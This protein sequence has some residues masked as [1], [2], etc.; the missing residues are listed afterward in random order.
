MQVT[1]VNSALKNEPSLI[2]KKPVD[3]IIGVM[4]FELSDNRVLIRPAIRVIR[5]GN[6]SQLWFSQVFAF[7]VKFV[8]KDG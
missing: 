5:L 4:F 6:A 2:N 3:G 1:A 8:Q 7:D